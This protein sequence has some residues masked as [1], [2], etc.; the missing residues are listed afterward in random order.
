M[1]LHCVDKTAAKKLKLSRFTVPRYV[2]LCIVITNYTFLLR[3]VLICYRY[4]LKISKELN[5]QT[6]ATL[7]NDVVWYVICNVL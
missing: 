6:A 1:S 7:K 4:G 3:N 5:R 2:P